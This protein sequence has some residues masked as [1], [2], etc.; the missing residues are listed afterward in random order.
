M[1]QSARR[2]IPYTE[3]K[4]LPEDNALYYEWHTYLQELPRLLAE[5]LEEKFI[6]IK[7]MEIIGLFDS[8]NAANEIAVQRFLM[9]DILIHQ[10]RSQEPLLRVPWWFGL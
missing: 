3:L 8:W 6:L 7:G 4:E 5:G 1:I 10:I 2:T 9:Q